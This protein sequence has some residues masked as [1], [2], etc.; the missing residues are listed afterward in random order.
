MS[1]IQHDGAYSFALGALPPI[2][3]ADLVRAH[4]AAAHRY[5]NA[6]VEIERWRR[7]EIERYWAERGGFA[8]TLSEIRGLRDRAREHPKGPDRN[9][10][11]RQADDLQHDVYRM[12][13]EVELASATTPESQRRK[14]RARQLR[15]ESKAR[16]EKLSDARIAALLDAESDCV[17]PRDRLRMEIA[18][19][20]ASRGQAVSGRVMNQ[21]MRAA[22]FASATD[23]IDQEAKARDYAAYQASG[24]SVGTRAVVAEAFERA[25]K[26]AAPEPPGF[27]RFD[28]HSVSL[29]VSFTV[30][31]GFT[32]HQLFTG[33]NTRASIERVPDPPRV[34]PGSRRSGKRAIL[35]LRIASNPDKSPVW[36]LFPITLDGREIPPDGRVSSIRVSCRRV[37]VH[38]RWS[39]VVC[40]SLPKARPLAP[41]R[42]GAVA[43]DLTW[44]RLSSGTIRS[45]YWADEHGLRGSIELDH[46]TLGAIDKSRD[47]Q[48]INSKLLHSVKH[49]QECGVVV[50]LAD[51]LVDR[52]ELPEWLAVV[53]PHVRRWRSGARLNRVAEHWISNRFA[54]DAEIFAKLDQW[55]RAW[56][57]LHEWSERGREKALAR[58]AEAFRIAIKPLVARYDTIVVRGL[59]LADMKRRRR[60]GQTDFAVVDDNVRSVMQLAAPGVFREQVTGIAKRRGRHV[61]SLDHEDL[62]RRC[63]QCGALCD[64]DRA[65]R[66][67]HECEHCG[68]EWD[69]H[70][71]V[72]RNMLDLYRERFGDESVSGSARTSGSTSKSRGRRANDVARVEAARTSAGQ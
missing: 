54:G 71:N 66:L 17:A 13:R 64:W 19:E 57:H 22:G 68:A 60:S 38:D 43:I 69:Q 9:A 10:L 70:Y 55:R 34:T 39:A 21:R 25:V 72:A 29:G 16:G 32:C 53:A 61:V 52:E 26:G 36:A 23:D 18:A 47:V 59:K 46:E 6:L 49:G 14:T 15:A 40:V 31:D 4:L 44:R 8:A 45:A 42:G 37:G 7:A 63:H 65:K 2:E 50:E 48:E 67:T 24:L 62:P 30:S 56:R 28:E 27:K 35:R 12:Q 20:Y 3:D 11:H 58:R 1:D 33:G 51:W 41:A 5:Y